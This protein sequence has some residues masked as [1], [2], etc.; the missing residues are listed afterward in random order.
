MVKVGGVGCFE[1]RSVMLARCLAITQ[2]HRQVAERE[3]GL[4]DRLVNLEQQVEGLSKAKE[5][6]A[7][8]NV[9]LAE[10]EHEL[11]RLQEV[12]ERK[13]VEAGQAEQKAKVADSRVTELQAEIAKQKVE[14][15]AEKLQLEQA[16]VKVYEDGFLKAMRQATAL[17]P[18]LDPSLF[19]ID[20]D[21]VLAADPMSTS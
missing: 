16:C 12:C 20:K 9:L 1:A 17:V 2:H 5:A 13:E 15:E 19:D 18:D 21:D 4:R 11:I 10:K 8:K 7:S 6:N 14:W 3:V